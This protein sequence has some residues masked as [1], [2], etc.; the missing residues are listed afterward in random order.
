M[1][2]PWGH[3]GS[4][5]PLDVLIHLLLGYYWLYSRGLHWSHLV[6][7]LFQQLDQ[8]VCLSSSS[9]GSSIHTSLDSVLSA[10]GWPLTLMDDV[11]LGRCVHLEGDASPFSEHTWGS[12]S[13]NGDNHE[14]SRS[15]STAN[16]ATRK[17]LGFPSV[18][19]AHEGVFVFIRKL[20]TYQRSVPAAGRETTNADNKQGPEFGLQLSDC[21]CPALGF[22]YCYI[23]ICR[24]TRENRVL[25]S[26]HSFPRI[27]SNITVMSGFNYYY[28]GSDWRT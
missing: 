12:Q 17:A 6:V 1:P 21:R 27:I 20:F 15:T 3:G 24:L 14:S 10:W 4:C 22:E 19:Q 26:K 28:Q 16:P 23:F 25:S 2:D 5:Q 11:T 9:S 13:P 8:D 18:C 7:L